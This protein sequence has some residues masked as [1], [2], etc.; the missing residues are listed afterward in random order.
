MKNNNP[1]KFVAEVSSNH[2]QNL[3]RCYEFIEVAANIGCDAV[4]F[5]LFKIDQLF[6]QEILE[7]SETHRARK[8]WELPE[9]YI[10]LLSAHC[11]KYNIEF[12]CTPFYLEA[13]SVLA[14][15]VDFF[16]IASYEL[17][18]DD[19]LVACAKTG[20]PVVISVGMANEAEILHA[21]ELLKSEGCIPTILHC[22][23]SYPTPAN[24]CNLASIGYLASLT[25]CPIGW[26]DHSRDPQV[27]RRAVNK[28]RASFI[29]FHIDLE[30]KGGEFDSGHCWLPE[31]IAPVIREINESGQLDGTASIKISPSELADREWRADP[32]DGLRPLKHIRGT[33]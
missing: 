29:E 14:P 24:E 23:S 31:E 12:S 8:Q 11:K 25:N 17:L 9:S 16:K 5:Q 4:K 22:I 27:V 13:V 19:L 3:A 20:V 18:W 26:S 33:F 2:H 15:H 28:W 30:G 21:V 10:P 32:S 6:S 1:C 7:K